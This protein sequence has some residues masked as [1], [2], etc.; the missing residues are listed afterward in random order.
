MYD[1]LN[2]RLFFYTQKGRR[3]G[4]GETVETVGGFGDGTP[5]KRS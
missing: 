2:L 3:A 5:E 4:E 1:V